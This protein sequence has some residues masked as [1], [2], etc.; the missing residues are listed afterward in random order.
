MG[1][2]R[3]A[4]EAPPTVDMNASWR[5][6]NGASQTFSG[7]LVNLT[8]PMPA[9]YT[10][11]DGNTNYGNVANNAL[12]ACTTNCFRVGVSST[13]PPGAQHWDATVIETITPLAQG[14]QKK[15]TLHIGDSFTDVPRG[16]FYKFVETL[17]HYS[18]TGGCGATTYCPTTATTRDQMSVFVLAAKEGAGFAPRACTTPVF[19]DVPASSPFCPFIEELARRGVV[20]GCGG[21]RYC[22]ADA[23]TREQMAVFTLRTLDPALVPPLCTTPVF[24]DVPATSPFCRW[25]EELARRHVVSGCGMGNY[26]PTSPVTRE[27]MGVFISATF[28]FV[29]YGV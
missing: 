5:N 1:P 27:Q 18:I 21:G 25:I 19:S 23:V 17:L 2:P 28:G 6:R 29:L 13:R 12:G 11:V 22:P 9:T 3:V 10:I 15:W 8:G 24:A 14:Q 4:E 26:C 16:G 20:G 7:V